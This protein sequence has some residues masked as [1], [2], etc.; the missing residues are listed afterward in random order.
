MAKPN[1]QRTNR[2]DAGVFT[3]G[4][5]GNGGFVMILFIRGYHLGLRLGLVGGSKPPF[6]EGTTAGLG[7]K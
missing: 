3:G 6:L 7:F 4:N 2:S 5:R 1:S